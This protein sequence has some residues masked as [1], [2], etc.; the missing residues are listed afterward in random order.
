MLC[1]LSTG[2]SVT[3][4]VFAEQRDAVAV[5]TLLKCGGGQGRILGSEHSQQVGGRLQGCV[6]P[7]RQ[8]WLGPFQTTPQQLNQPDQHWL[9]ILPV[10]LATGGRQQV[11][12]GKGGGRRFAQHAD[13]PIYQLD[14][15]RSFYGL[16]I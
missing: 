6:R 13:S 3:L 11:G 1:H 7:A 16:Q 4:K 15:A 8:A 5:R 12:K 2:I 10:L 9:C 14:W